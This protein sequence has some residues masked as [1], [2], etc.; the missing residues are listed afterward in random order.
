MDN[1]H[2]LIN[3]EF[4]ADLFSL[5]HS[6]CCHSCSAIGASV[7]SSLG[8]LLLI[9]CTFRTFLIS[10]S[11]CCCSSLDF[12][13]NKFS[14]RSR[15][16]MRTRCV[17]SSASFIRDSTFQR[18]K[19]LLAIYSNSSQP[20]S[21]LLLAVWPILNN[22]QTYVTTSWKLPWSSSRRKLKSSSFTVSSGC[23][24]ARGPS[25]LLFVVHSKLSPESCSSK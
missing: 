23:L 14:R 24:L 2:E 13:G 18:V 19:H 25:K 21:T 20:S 12:Y 1:C 3:C 15:T 10:R 9:N 6:S 4:F 7:V 16:W 8:S 17:M 5:F 11:L 22:D